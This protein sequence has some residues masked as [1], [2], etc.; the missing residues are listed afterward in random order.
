[1]SVSQ[2]KLALGFRLNAVAD[3]QSNLHYAALM[4]NEIFGGSPAS[5]LFLNVREKM[6]LCYYCS[7]S[8]DRYTGTMTVS[9]GIENKNKET[10][11]KAILSELNDIKNKK[12]SSTELDA[13][14]KSLLNGYR[15]IEDNPYDLQS[16]YANRAFFGFCEDIELAKSKII[17]V[18][19]DDISNI[20][21]ETV[22][23]SVFSVEGS[24]GVSEEEC[25]EE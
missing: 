2:G 24:A 6:S 18:T 8:Y 25:Y 5:K 15:Q 11:Q 16:Y 14:K 23:D 7:S 10:V 1:M 3:G 21:A 17:S 12:I 13:A 20:A 22:C 9:S 4:F 19:V